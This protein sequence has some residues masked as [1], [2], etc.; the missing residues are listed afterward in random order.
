[1][2]FVMSHWA[3]EGVTFAS[4]SSTNPIPLSVSKSKV[5]QPP[6]KR[7]IP[8]AE[9]MSQITVLKWKCRLLKTGRY[10]AIEICL[11]HVLDVGTHRLWLWHRHLAGTYMLCQLEWE[12]KLADGRE[13]EKIVPNSFFSLNTFPT[14]II[15]V[16]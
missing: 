9:W 8:S 10:I 7:K 14:I 12:G 2:L 11:A 6:S 4:V 16:S 15:H 1:M 5:P 13:K 3:P